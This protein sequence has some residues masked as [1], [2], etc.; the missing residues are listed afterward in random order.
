MKKV[1]YEERQLRKAYVSGL[2]RYWRTRKEKT[3]K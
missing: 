2:R 3:E 1:N